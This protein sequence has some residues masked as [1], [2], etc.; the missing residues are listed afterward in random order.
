[1][2]LLKRWVY[3]TIYASSSSLGR[4]CRRLLGR[5][6]QDLCRRR[7]GQREVELCALAK[8]AFSPD[9]AA[10]GLDDVLDD[11][12]AETGSP[13]SRERALSTR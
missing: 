2:I 9:A 13:D 4:G 5:L 1:M 8:F 10:M 11:G 12:E 7:Q 3:K 6:R